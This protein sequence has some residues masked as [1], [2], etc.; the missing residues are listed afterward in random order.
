MDTIQAQHEQEMKAVLDEGLAE[1]GILK[2]KIRS[3]EGEVQ[4]FK[5]NLNLF[6]SRLKS[7]KK[8]RKRKLRNCLRFEAFMKVEKKRLSKKMK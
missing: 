1:S 2:G 4:K 7:Y 5:E 6:W 8:I 3:L